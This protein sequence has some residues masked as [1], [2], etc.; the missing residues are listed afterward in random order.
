MIRNKA[1]EFEDKT[2]EIARYQQQADSISITFNKGSTYPYGR[3]RVR[4]L[5]KPTPLPI[6]EGSCVEVDGQIWTG[7]RSVLVFRSAEGQWAHIVYQRKDGSEGVS[8]YLASQVEVRADVGASGI[9]ADVRKYWRAVLSGMAPDDPLQDPH[10]R[11]P[12]VHPGS[13]LGAYLTGSPIE[14]RDL[15]TPPI[16]PFRCN[17]SQRAAVE[18]ALTRSVSVIEGPPGTGKT[19]TIL[20]LIANIV[21][22]QG[23]V[24]V[25]SFTNSAVANV[26]EKLDELGF[27]HIIADLGNRDMRNAFFAKQSERNTEVSRFVSRTPPQPDERRLDEVDRQLRELQRADR[28]KAQRQ[29]ELAAFRLEFEHFERHLHD[30]LPDLEN[31][32]L[33]R[34]SSDRILDYLAE[35]DLQHEGLR[36]GLLRRIGNYFR[37]GP[38]SDLDPGDT[39]LV[40]ALQRAYYRKRIGELESE[41]DRLDSELEGAKFNDLAEEHQRLSTEKLHAELGDRYRSRN[42]RKYDHETYRQNRNFRSFIDDHPT[43]LSTCHSLR[44]CVPEGFLLDYLIIDEASQVNPLAAALAMSEDLCRNLVVVGDSQQLAPVEVTSES[45]ATPPHPAYDVRKSVLESVHELHGEGLPSQLLREHYRCDPAIIGFCNKSFYDDELIPFSPNGMQ[46]P[47]LVWRTVE[48]NHMRRYSGGGRMNRREIDVIDD[49]VIPLHCRG[50]DGDDIGVTT[51]Y[52]GQVAA[53]E[54]VLD[55]GL[56]NTVHKF[57]GRQK[58]V[59][60]LTTVLDESRQG[61]IGLKFVDDPKLI[62]VAV[63]R[64]ID[65]FVL[66]TNHDTLP[67]SR[68]VRDLVGYIR[69]HGFDESVLDS[70]IVS[71]FDLLYQNYARRLR[72]LARRRR[73]QL[74]Y[75]SEDIAWTVLHDILAEPAYLHLKAVP[76]VLVTQVLPNLDRL[77][78][79]QRH[80]VGNRASLDFVLYNRVTNEFVLAIEVDGFEY[81]AN[82]PEQQ[83]RDALKNEI[84][85]RYGLRLLRLPT[86]GSREPERIRRELDEADRA[87]ARST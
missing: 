75:P 60:I 9:A 55:S 15:A 11:M 10:E 72:P 76:Q 78:E 51:P 50:V 28:E 79:P 6:P 40:L 47:M 14:T 36:P 17:L 19:E 66:V 56:I 42:R 86:T 45:T 64:A 21:V 34:R 2:G 8:Y 32:P 82:K 80:Y 5:R 20:N 12:Y 49:E 53:A 48:G 39:D 25:V 58:R 24:A 13:A 7:V 23:M 87:L 16:Y 77:D 61:R 81:H 46:P 18:N 31:L 33:L 85:R 1:G 83:R 67:R 59:V 35:S 62:N 44:K 52:R 37:F 29:Q 54:D 69:Y 43:V 74:R 30:D 4:V 41:L 63:S 26:K 73:H 71:I 27:G 57:Q 65:R 22:Q 38:T 3:D 68:H 84:M 70:D